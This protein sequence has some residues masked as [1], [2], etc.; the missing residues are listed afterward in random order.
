MEMNL[1][2]PA[3]YI[4]FFVL[5]LVAGLLGCFMWSFCLWLVKDEKD[6]TKSSKYS[7]NSSNITIVVDPT[8]PVYSHQSLHGPKIPP[9]VGLSL[10][11]PVHSIYSKSSRCISP[12]YATSDQALEAMSIPVIVPALQRRSKIR[13]SGIYDD[14]H[15]KKLSNTI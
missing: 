7:E 3:A 9:S 14:L 12:R 1:T 11:V 5:L 6:K 15:L 13:R 8:K 10:P 2:L 4:L